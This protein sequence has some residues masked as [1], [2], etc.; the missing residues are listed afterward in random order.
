MPTGLRDSKTISEKK[1]A[2]LDPEIKAMGLWAIGRAS[3][4]EIDEKGILAATLLAMRRAWE[5]IDRQMRKDAIIIVDGD[6][7][8]PIDGKMII[9]PKADLLC[10]TVS[11][12]SILAKVCRDAEVTALHGVDERYGWNRNKGYGTKDH[13]AA[14][15]EFGPSI[16]HRKSFN[17]VRAMLKRK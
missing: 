7:A 8:P 14:I 16:Y 10:P 2:K 1:R 12:A 5:G 11:A 6:K 15:E 17:P 4:A 3:I 9:M 13:F